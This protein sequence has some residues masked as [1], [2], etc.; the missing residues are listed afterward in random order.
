MPHRALLL[1]LAVLLMVCCAWSQKPRFKTLAECEA[2]EQEWEQW[3]ASNVPK[4]KAAMKD[5]DRL[6]GENATLRFSNEALE[7]T[8]I[9]GDIGTA[10]VGIG[11]GVFGAF[12]LVRGLRRLWQRKRLGPK[13]LLTPTQKQLIALI[14]GAIW[15]SV[16]AMI[17]ANDDALSKHPVNLL[18]TVLVYSL[19]ALSFGWIGFWW[20]GKEKEKAQATDG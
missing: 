10:G 19:P 12:W 1:L 2:K 17:G 15:V 4:C 18:F 16:A 7:H 5:A 9:R 11:I 13:P 8:R 14:L 20:F 6:E 3:S